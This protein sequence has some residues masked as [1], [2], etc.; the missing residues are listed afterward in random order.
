MMKARSPKELIKKGVQEPHKIPPFFTRK[1]K[2][3]LNNYR[4]ERYRKKNGI[5]LQKSRIHDLIKED[6]FILIILDSCRFDYF[7]QEYENFVTG[8][9]TCVWSAGNRTPLWAPNTWDQE[10]D[11]DYISTVG[12]PISADSYEHVN[13][14]YDPEFNQTIRVPHSD[15]LSTADPELVTD[16]ALHHF[17]KANRL[18]GVVHYVQ[19][20][21]PYIGDKKIFHWKVSSEKLRYFSENNG[22]RDK[23]PDDML[24]GSEY[25]MGE[26]IFEL[27]IPTEELLQIP[28]ET[29]DV[30]DRINDG[31]L[32]DEVLRQAYRD[33]LSLVL[34][35]VKRFVEHLDCTVIISAD[36]GEHL[37]GYTNEI[38]KY[39]HPDH[40]H[41]VLREVPWL[42]VDNDSKNKKSLSSIK[43]P[44]E[45]LKD[46][47][48]TAPEEDVQKHLHALGYIS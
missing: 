43:I 8:D 14:N 32:T 22:F 21:K 28:K 15:I 3:K 24:D 33:N 30:R 27:G 18:R 12:Y 23:I 34:G 9:L 26:D 29:Y 6:E 19:P 31:G 41:P 35:E 38:P 40:T 44:D 25:V 4:W 11:L 36:H 2:Y 48:L 17:S 39:F 47:E 46:F 5:P 20:H 16:I 42:V 37:G 10:Y 45:R 1:L 7:K 13:W